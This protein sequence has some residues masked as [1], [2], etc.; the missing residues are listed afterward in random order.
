MKRSQFSKAFISLLIFTMIF[1]V[2]VFAT[3]NGSYEVT[4]SASISGTVNK[5]DVFIYNLSVKNVSGSNLTGVNINISG[6][7]SAVSTDGLT[8]LSINNGVTVNKAIPLKFNG[9]SQKLTVLVV[10]GT[11]GHS[12][13][14]TETI[15]KANVAGDS[16]PAP[17]DTSKY[18]PQFLLD[19][20]G[21]T[22]VFIAGQRQEFKFNIKNITS[23]SATEVY[24]QITVDGDSP[25][26]G[27][28]NAMITPKH[29]LSGNNSLDLSLHIE[30]KSSAKSGFYTLPL[31]IVSKNVYGV[32]TT[33]TKNI[34][35]EVVNRNVLPS[36]VISDLN[37][38][39]PVL[40]PGQDNVI[41][42]DLKN[43]GSIGIKNMTAKLS[44]LT[45]DGIKLLADSAEKKITSIDA[46]DTDFITYTIDVSEKLKA[47]QVELNLDLTYFD[48][49]GASYTE[50]IT[51]LFIN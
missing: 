38:K 13:I 12:I 28:T 41:K 14:H 18:I 29:S 5:D 2:T 3:S 22:P 40:T 43:L 42:I 31:K 37:F 17:V 51:S 34:Q 24:A 50:K 7:F 23:Y 49:N 20:A 26:D 30:T 36:V 11:N 46:K 44:G 39:T 15:T 35:V 1:N 6:G 45:M 48:Q 47:D 9:T 4:G 8:N 21:N 10:D 16:N 33:E 25:F 32:S 19:Y 27:S